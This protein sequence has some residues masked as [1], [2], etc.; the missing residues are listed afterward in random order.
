VDSWPYQILLYEKL[1]TKDV[2][3]GDSDVKYKRKF[4]SVGIWMYAALKEVAWRQNSISSG[5][6]SVLERFERS[7]R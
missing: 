2:H 1:L 3:P 4:L 7:G 5:S 6:E